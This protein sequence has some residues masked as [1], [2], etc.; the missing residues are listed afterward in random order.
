MGTNQDYKNRALASLEGN[1]GKTAIATLIFLI[2]SM[3][4]SW[5]VT[6]PMGDNLVMSYSTQGFLTLLCLPL[7]WGFVVYFLNLIRNDNTDY[8]RL[9]D[10]Y[11]DFIRIFLAEFLVNLATGI[12][13]IL[14]IIPGIIIGSG[15]VM[16]GFI[17]K[18]DKEISAVDAMKKSWEMTD[19]HK[20]ALVLLF[21]SFLGW[22]ILSIFT[23]G[24][25]MLFL[26]PYMQT[27]LAHC[28]EDLKAEKGM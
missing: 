26:Y 15:L 11:K 23:L 4:I 27:A 20:G 2:L 9:F 12:G 8:E 6:T 7:G 18:D 5:T 28:Y 25:G 3:G 17:L 14:L 13:M 1:W 16:T 19:G 22:I 24:I 10:G 21:L